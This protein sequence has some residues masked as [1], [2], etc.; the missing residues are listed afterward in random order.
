MEV[1]LA[2]G[3]AQLQLAVVVL[4][5]SG[6]LQAAARL[7]HEQVGLQ[8]RVEFETVGCGSR[9]DDVIEVAKRQG[10]EHCAKRSFAAVD[11]N[12]LVRVGI[13]IKLFLG[14]KRPA[15]RQRDVLV[16]QED[17]PAR[18]GI[19]GPGNRAGLQ[20]VMSERGFVAKLRRHRPGGLDPHHA[21][22]GPQVVD[23]AV[24][25]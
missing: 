20:M 17:E 4:I 11:E 5:A 14:L 1:A 18:D 6:N 21:S 24:G 2:K 12:Q 19:A 16:A 23:N 15:P 9:N 13:A 22:G 8:G 10:P 25:A 7:D 3:S